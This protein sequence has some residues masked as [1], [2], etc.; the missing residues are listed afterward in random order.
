M[1]N[2]IHDQN[3]AIG[4]PYSE[5]DKDWSAFN[6]AQLFSCLSTEDQ[7]ELIRVMREKFAVPKYDKFSEDEIIS[8]DLEYFEDMMFEPHSIVDD[9]IKYSSSCSDGSTHQLYDDYHMGLI[10]HGFKVYIKDLDEDVGGQTDR[11]NK[12]IFINSEY[13]DDK[14]IILHEMIHAHEVILDSRESFYHDILLLCLYNNLKDK[15]P[16]LDAKILAHTHV[17][18]GEIISERGGSHNIL[19]LLKSL[20]L[21]LR[22]GFELGTVCSYGRKEIFNGYA[23]KRLLN[24]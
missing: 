8:N 11:E 15:I 17:I 5:I 12:E 21:D 3:K 23:T 4:I 20:D 16:D 14:A 10:E 22:C 24:E 7:D 19:F 2:K 1:T 9:F 13:S 6:A 18:E